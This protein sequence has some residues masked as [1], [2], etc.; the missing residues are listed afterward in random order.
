MCLIVFAYKCHPKYRLILASNRDE[1]YQ[2]PTLPANFWQKHPS[3]VAG[4]DQQAGGTWIGASKE[5]R[6]AAVTNFREGQPQAAPR[7][8]GEL[9]HHF[10][11]G[12]QSPLEFANETQAENAQYNG[13]NLLLADQQDLIYCSNRSQKIETLSPGIYSLSNHLLNT[14]WPKAEHAKHELS[15]LISSDQVDTEQLIRCMQRRQP[16]P[17]EQLPATGVGLELERT[18]SPPFIVA[19]SYGTRCTTALL[20]ETNGPMHFVEQNY[21]PD[22]EPGQRLEYNWKTTS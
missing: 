4:I 3:V 12:Q 19:D 13:F 11:T 18:L 8:R 17:D 10:L 21:L 9:T 16:F 2:R 7:S 6:L 5:G 20:W 14:P 15:G 22:G 1:F